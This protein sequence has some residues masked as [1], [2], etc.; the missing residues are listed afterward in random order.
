ME[1]IKKIAQRKTNKKMKKKT[2]IH[3]KRFIRMKRKAGKQLRQLKNLTE[4]KIRKITERIRIADLGLQNAARFKQEKEEK[5]AYEKIRSQAKLFYSYARKISSH[6]NPISP[7]VKNGSVIQQDSATV[8]NEHYCSVFNKKDEEKLPED[9][10]WSLE[11]LIK[12]FLGCQTY[13][14]QSKM[15]RGS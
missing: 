14:S 13:A 2:P 5:E 8:L 3:L 1:A 7:F 9:Y 6:R 4:E 11:D 15:T 12:I 10:A